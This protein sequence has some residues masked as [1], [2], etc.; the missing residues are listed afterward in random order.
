MT[1]CAEPKRQAVKLSRYR[2]NQNRC[3]A[4]RPFDD[5]TFIFNV[6]AHSHAHGGMRFGGLRGG[7]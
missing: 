4:K 3:Q 5:Q 6:D 7:E 1:A 2:K